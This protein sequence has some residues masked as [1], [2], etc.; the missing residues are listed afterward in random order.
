MPHPLPA[1]VIVPMVGDKCPIYG[2]D[3]S[4]LNY[5]P[6]AE[7]ERNSPREEGH[8]D[9]QAG[10]APFRP[11]L[12]PGVISLL[13]LGLSSSEPWLEWTGLGPREGWGYVD[14]MSPLIRAGGTGVES[15]VGPELC[16]ECTCRGSEGPPYPAAVQTLLRRPPLAQ[17]PFLKLETPLCAGLRRGKRPA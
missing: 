12:T 9:D 16:G 14:K 17:N 5:A 8:A 7:T 15:A 4:L 6:K 2:T 11:S 1:T 3:F 10:T 13:G